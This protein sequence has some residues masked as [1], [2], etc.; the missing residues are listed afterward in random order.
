MLVTSLSVRE[1]VVVVAQKRIR[2]SVV[3]HGK[4][5]Y[6]FLNQ[7][8]LGGKVLRL[9]GL[10]SLEALE[11]SCIDDRLHRLPSRCAERPGESLDLGIGDVNGHARLP[12]EGQDEV[13]DTGGRGLLPRAKPGTR[14]RCLDESVAD[15]LGTLGKCLLAENAEPSVRY[16]Y[17]SC[18]DCM[19]R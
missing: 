17:A 5:G 18:R 19:D 9:N 8:N 1:A 6:L 10:D 15:G 16:G 3:D 13:T 2:T 4:S 11:Q 12:L 7:P 14:L